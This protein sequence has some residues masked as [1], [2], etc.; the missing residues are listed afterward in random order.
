MFRDSAGSNPIDMIT[1]FTYSPSD[2]ASPGM[3]KHA[4]LGVGIMEKRSI[5][6]GGRGESPDLWVES[7]TSLA[8]RV[9]FQELIYENSYWWISSEGFFSHDKIRVFRKEQIPT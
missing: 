9:I 1:P 3:H 7:K 5:R 8:Q 6:R 4:Y 2:S